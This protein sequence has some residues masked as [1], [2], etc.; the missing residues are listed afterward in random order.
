[1]IELV[2]ILVVLASASTVI[3]LWWYAVE[4]STRSQH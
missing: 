1:M 2:R 3:A 4:R